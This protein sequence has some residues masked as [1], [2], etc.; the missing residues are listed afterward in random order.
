[1]RL[2]PALGLSLHGCARSVVFEVDDS[3]DHGGLLGGAALEVVLDVALRLGVVEDG[4]VRREL[5]VCV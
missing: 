5:K 3:V 4:G 2:L 1:M